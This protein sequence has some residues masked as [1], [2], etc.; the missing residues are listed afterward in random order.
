MVQSERIEL[1]PIECSVKFRKF[2]LAEI[3]LEEARIAGAS[4]EDEDVVVVSSKFAAISEG[5]CMKLSRVKVTDKATKLAEK[6][7]MNPALCQLVLRESSSILGGVPGFLLAIKDDVLAPNAGIDLSNAPPDWAVLYPKNPS[8]SAEKLRLDLLRLSN[9]RLV[10]L[11]NLG[12]ILSDSRVTPTRLG[13]VGVAIA[14]AGI[15]P[16]IDMR[17]KIDLFQKELKVTLIAL[18]DQLS[19]AAEICMGEARESTPVVII[20]GV[21]KAFEKP[22]NGFER[23][24]TISQDKCIIISGLRSSGI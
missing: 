9:Q 24:M 6:Y 8:F 20:R 3:I 10:N 18:A 11:K 17:G 23:S 12:V 16:T 7:K 1:I 15:R 22:R 5:R 13:T 2:N 14:T 4:L 21:K 19:S